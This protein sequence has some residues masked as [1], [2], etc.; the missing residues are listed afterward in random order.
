[1][2]PGNDIEVPSF[3]VYLRVSFWITGGAAR[4]G[5]GFAR[6]HRG[7]TPL[8]SLLVLD[9]WV[10]RTRVNLATTPACH[11]SHGLIMHLQKV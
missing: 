1:M 10:F 5:G 9:R 11:T 8:L 2:V 6:A 4:L 3:A 7:N